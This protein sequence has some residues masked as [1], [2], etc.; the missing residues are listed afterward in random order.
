[1]VSKTCIL[2]VYMYMQTGRYIAFIINGQ[3]KAYVNGIIGL[4]LVSQPSLS[5]TFVVY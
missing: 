4:F 3:I 5:T 2:Y 1:M